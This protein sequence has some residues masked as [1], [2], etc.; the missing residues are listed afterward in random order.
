MDRWQLLS[1][2][3]VMVWGVRYKDEISE[4]D[5]DALRRL[6]KRQKHYLVRHSHNDCDD[7]RW[8]MAE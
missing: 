5:K 4:E 2:V 1:G 7:A 6:M 8:Q 3:W